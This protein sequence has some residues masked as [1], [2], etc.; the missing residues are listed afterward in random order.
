MTAPTS[1]PA[2]VVRKNVSQYLIFTPSPKLYALCLPLSTRQPQ[3]FAIP[4]TCNKAPTKKALCL[5]FAPSFD[6]SFYFPIIELTQ[7]QRA[8]EEPPTTTP[9]PVSG[10]W[11]ALRCGGGDGH[12]QAQPWV[13]G[14]ILTDKTPCR[15]GNSPSLLGRSAVGA[16]QGTPEIPTK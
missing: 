10:L 1:K 4:Q 15:K 6:F 16:Y 9:P 7:N 12:G 11:L 2:P 3:V 14:R 5:T 13:M 8:R